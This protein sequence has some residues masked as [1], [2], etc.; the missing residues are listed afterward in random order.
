MNISGS[1]FFL[2]FSYANNSASNGHCPHISSNF[3]KCIIHSVKNF[4]GILGDVAYIMLDVLAKIQDPALIYCRVQ[5]K[6]FICTPDNTNELCTQICYCSYVMT[7]CPAN[8]IGSGRHHGSR[9]SLA[10]CFSS[11]FLVRFKLDQYLI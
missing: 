1:C 2:L 7:G 3:E 4:K 6:T 10:F 11:D 8:R 9:N 5:K